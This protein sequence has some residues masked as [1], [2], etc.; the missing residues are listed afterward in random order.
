M[1][2]TWKQA[3]HDVYVATTDGEYAGFVAVDGTG[4][5]LHDRHSRRL[6]SYPSLSAARSALESLGA[7]RGALE[8]FGTSAGSGATARRPRRSA[9]DRRRPSASRSR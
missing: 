5:V 9:R 6:G 1:N 3:D 8:P 4:H 7:S 2:I